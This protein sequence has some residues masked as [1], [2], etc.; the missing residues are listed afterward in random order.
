M[1]LTVSDF[2]AVANSTFF[3]TR[4]IAIAKD[5]TAKLGNFVFSA[6]KKKN[7][8]VMA[9]FKE[10]LENEYGALGTHAFDTIL[11]A[12]NQLNKS[13]RACDVKAALSKLQT[14]RETRF[15]DELSRQLDTSPK[16]RQLPDEMR[17]AIRR[18]IADSPFAD[19]D[20][21]SCKT[22]GDMIRLA[23][24]RIE[25]SIAANGGLNKDVAHEFNGRTD[26]ESAAKP[27]EAVGLRNL[28]SVLTKDAT[29]IADQI[30]KGLVGSG[31]RINRSAT[32]P[33]LLEKLKTNGV[34]PGFIYRNDWSTADTHGF[35]ANIN[36][37]ESLAALDRLK[38]ADPAFAKECEKPNKDGTPKSIR[39]QIML[40]GR[41]H[42]AAMAAV[43]EFL[44][45]RAVS[46][47]L[48]TNDRNIG[49]PDCVLSLAQA[50]K[51]Q[52]SVEDLKLLDRGVSDPKNAAILRE[53]KLE[54]FGAIRDAVMG[55]RKGD[56]EY[57]A[58]PVF[59][60]FSERHIM[61][62][63]YNESERVFTKS[64]AH[65]GS[66]MR[67]E[68]ILASRKPVLGHIYRLQTA[69]SADN[70]S[71]GAVTEALANDLTRLAGIPSQE[72]Q[73]VRGQYSDGHP[74]LMLE[75][76]FADGYQDMEA[77]FIKDGRIVPPKDD[78]G[79]PMNLESLGKYKAF[80]L[81]TAD[82]DAVGKRG[83]NKG[84][85][86]GQF[87]AIDP[88]HS[89]EGNSKYL[90]VSDDF[91]FRDTYG[92]SSK[93]RFKNFSV[94]DDDTR[95]SKLQGLAN[96]RDIA[97]S[98]KFAK[99]FADYRAAFDPTEK[100]ISDEEVALRTKI[101]AD[102]AKKE[103][104]FNESLSKL[105][106]VGGM[107]LEL[108]DALAENGAAMQE[109]GIETIANLEKLCSPTTWTSKHGQ[110]PLK[111]LEVKPETRI[112]WRAGVDGDNIVYHC[113]KP[114]PDKAREILQN[115]AAENG[116]R[117]EM[118]EF[119]TT[120]LILPKSVAEQFFAA[121]NEDKVA[122]L[123]HPKEHA[124]RNVGGDGLLE[125]VL[126]EPF[127][128]GKPPQAPGAPLTSE[129]L[130]DQ[131]DV[132]DATGYV[133]KLPKIHYE[134]MATTTCPGFHRP[135][136]IGQLRAQMEARIR[137]GSEILRSLLSGN[138]SRF[139][140]SEQNISALTIALHIAALKK[141]EFMYRGSFSVEDPQGNIARWLDSSPDVYLRSS[142]HAR[143]YQKLQVDGHL[144]MPRG[145]DVREGMGGL[146]NGMRTFHYFSLPDPNHIN[147]VD[148]GSGPKR[149]LFLKCETF[150]IYWSTAQLHRKDMQKARS[151]GMH[152]RWA[153]FG[154]V[155]ESIAHMMSLFSSFF[156]PKDAPGIRKE[157]MPPK[158]V[159]L[160]KSAEWELRAN[161]FIKLAER[162]DL[163]AVLKGGGLK[164]FLDN[165]FAGIR[166]LPDDRT[167][168]AMTVLE[169]YLTAMDKEVT[170]LA[171]S[172]E[173]RMGNEI[174]IDAKD[175]GV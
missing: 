103:K 75:A 81:L 132:E 94:F 74:K 96:L 100:G 8:A 172:G 69:N 45:E 76:K 71:A 173:S 28:T 124:M 145:Y 150:G 91:S 167:D 52:F 53:A 38:A 123:T 154:N 143:P 24:R 51:K 47:A 70:I 92:K 128:P 149:R 14:L 67:P 116:A 102:I 140:A 57:D 27:N 107:Q 72:L 79:R 118:D 34:E 89:L 170:A 17:K 5:S 61:K 80:F 2:Q 3:G 95:F 98:G 39:Q 139:E 136:S 15:I 160:I 93:P 105:L 114:I 56:A 54:L 10:A 31:M 106:R 169:P 9:A 171:G 152:T 66:F 65:A 159:N 129:Q 161:G 156:T 121:F 153:R 166:E 87:F 88:G 22:T 40:A 59:K 60:H 78:D 141:G 63:D 48:G 4:D 108:Y 23:T 174:L 19:C 126:Y 13:L 82:R 99:L 6:G 12:R 36:S 55:I 97:N 101:I 85:A 43:S 137:R 68:R 111:H 1:A 164:M 37:Q 21:T 117:C 165:L 175:F 73:I 46:I 16:F 110:V 168:E 49:V 151:E 84:F 30:K 26:T 7:M 162:S 33:I 125:A 122:Q 11:G 158:L 135:R 131:L 77:G 44:L 148:K 18:E 146:L 134:K 144:N 138:V 50:L 32:N 41:A 115:L 127:E 20:L 142:T 130:P 86:H 163:D 83:Q 133:V 62:L 109:G 90:E 29:S 155:T 112:P 58:S 147:E 157:N 35:M 104:E 119:G 113:D 64:A 25:K 42:P 120:R